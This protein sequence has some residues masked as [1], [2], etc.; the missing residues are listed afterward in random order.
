MSRRGVVLVGHGGVP[1]D[2]PRPLVT[3]LK[4][5]EAQRRT[6]GRE[7]L[8]EERELDDRVRNWP[9]T[10]ENDPYRFGLERLAEELRPRLGDDVLV[11]AYNEFCAPTIE[12]AVATLVAQDI[13][14]VTVV[15]SM[16][17]PGGVHSEIDIP[18]SL[19]PLQARWPQLVLHYAWPVPLDL[20]A[21]L[22]VRHLHRSTR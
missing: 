3:R 17:T 14:E 15:P 4:T 19:A 9:R 1:R 22:L 8:A 20:V 21:D 16:M 5:L 18:E 13:T 12:Q 11:L 2:C 10:P 6:S 7:A